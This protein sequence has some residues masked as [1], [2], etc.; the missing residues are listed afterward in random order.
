MRKIH[1]ILIVFSALAISCFAAKEQKTKKESKAVTYAVQPDSSVYSTLGKTMID[2]LFSPNKVTC[3]AIKGKAQVDDEDYELE[4]HYV[5]DSLITRLS[6]SQINM[7]QFFILSDKN[8][9]M[10]DSVKVRSPYVPSLEFCFEKKKQQVHV[11][12][13][14]SDFSWTIFY[15]DKKQG[16]WN[17][18]EKRIVGR[19]CKMI[20]NSVNK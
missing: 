19:Y 7:L 14:R 17:Y 11:L 12:V 15:D 5:R 2:I 16:N 18:H 13:S 10:Q 3:Y 20:C 6:T 8:N 1:F 9:Y 4:P